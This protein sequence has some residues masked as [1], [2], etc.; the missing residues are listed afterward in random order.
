MTISRDQ[1][2]AMLDQ[3]LQPWRF[4]DYCP[5]GLQVE[6]R[7]QVRKIITGVT[8]SQRFIDLA[9]ER[10]ADVL[11]VHHG[12]FWKNENPCIT[13][14]K[15][16][17]LQALLNADVSLLVYHLPLDAHPQLGN[18][19]QLARRLGLTIAGALDNTGQPPLALWAQ[20]PEPL[21]ASEWLRHVATVLGSPV[22]HF[23]GQDRRLQRVAWCT[24]AAQDWIE[25]AAAQQMDAYLSGE[26]SE[27]VVHWAEET[28]VHYLAAGH[29]AT[30]RYGVQAV[31]EWLQQQCGVEHEFIDCFVEV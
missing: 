4:K 23:P 17:R 7:S 5:N 2:V 19:V 9:L 6:G 18:N 20:L 29:H 24:G 31:G 21:P 12:F 15:K 22:R 11:L 25:Q 13:G 27:P 28:G 3:E 16:K 8:A 26:V 14:I 30:E 10:Q 1:L